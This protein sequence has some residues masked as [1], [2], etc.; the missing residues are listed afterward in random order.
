MSGKLDVL[1]KLMQVLKQHG[2]KV[3][4]LTDYV[5]MVK[6][7]H[8][9]LK[10]YDIFVAKLY[11][12]QKPSEEEA[13]LRMFRNLSKWLPN[14]G[15]VGTY[16]KCSEGLNLQDADVIIQFDVPDTYAEDLQ[17]QDRY[18]SSLV[19][20]EKLVFCLGYTELVSKTR[21]WFTKWRQL[22]QSKWIC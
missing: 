11:G 8:A 15:I 6:M 19:C 17:S 4:I 16:K 10:E 9:V 12:N 2:H 21:F 18:V 7:I 1:I 13:N 20:V 3:L 14:D 5:K 22:I